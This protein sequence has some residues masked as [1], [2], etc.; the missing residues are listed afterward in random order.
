MSRAEDIKTVKAPIVDALMNAYDKHSYHFHI[1]GHTRGK[2][3]YEPF[4]NFMGNK[5]FQC[6]MTD[7]FDGIGTL[8]P[9]TGP[10]KEA[11]E[12]CAELFGAQQSLFL[13]NGS[14]VGNIAIAMGLSLQGKKII[15][16]RNCHRSVLTGMIISGAE[17]L[18]I[19]PEKLD[20]WALWG[21]I[22]PADVETLLSKNKDVEMV[23]LTNPTYEG[24]VSDIGEISKICKKYD[25]PLVVDEAHG[26]LWKFNKAFPT[27]SLDLGADI[28][29]QSFHKTGGSMSQTSV[30]H[31]SKNTKLNVEALVHAL[32][33]LQ[34]TS[35]SIILLAGLDAARA[36][37][38]TQEGLDNIQTAIDN[39]E[40]L[41][42]EIS[43]LNHITQL[44]QT[45]NDPTKI[46]IKAD[47]LSGIQLETIL[48]QDYNIEVE[49]ASDKGILILS[50]IG[51][52]HSDFEYL[53]DCLKE[54]DKQDYTKF[55]KEKTKHMPM[56]IPEIR[57]NLRQAF[58]AE[59]EEVNKENA[60]G[61]ISAEVIAE[62]PPGI[63]ILL[64]GELITA[65][66]LPYLEQYD[67]L[68]VVKNA[69]CF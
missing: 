23:W 1:P 33:L 38:E 60:I 35:P 54:I 10:I 19:I 5:F 42:H 53:A 29:V 34:T 64:P 37:L 24:V 40:F 31:I 21:K 50:N 45:P 12:L 61:R 9:P 17:P 57:M 55:E 20:D 68:E 7:E 27:P 13:L 28:V 39:A 69:Y 48:E 2:G 62:C 63:A 41:S 3:I 8:N 52:E 11:E 16:N 65:E 36:Q 43:K 47:N 15:V 26:T 30:M 4:K 49:S 25:V 56:L 58:Y 46:F 66:H 67:K 44:K 59:K 32:R 6:D 22:N 14:T 18:W 51:N